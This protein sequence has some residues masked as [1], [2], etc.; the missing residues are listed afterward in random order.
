[1]RR[2]FS[3]LLVFLLPLSLLSCRRA[4]EEEVLPAARAL[5]ERSELVNAILIGEGA[6]RG[7]GGF[8]GYDFVS[9]AWME[10]T[11]IYTVADLRAAT[12]AVYTPEVADI[13][14]R[15]AL[16]NNDE[17]LADYRD[18]AAPGR[19]LLILCE[20]EGW[21]SGEVREYLYDTMVMTASS[22]RTA[23]VTLDVRITAEGAEAQTRT[24]TLPLVREED[25]WRCDKLTYIAPLIL[26]DQ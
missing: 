14:F 15:K 1:M 26:V 21:Y 17:V 6:P 19:G 12:L 7:D 2:L 5:I 24:L 9:E 10:E 18:R 3:L 16:T 4:S 23:T 22:S 25:G 13:L 8:E 11:G 20:R